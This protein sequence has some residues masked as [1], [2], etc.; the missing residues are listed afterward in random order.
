MYE[1]IAKMFRT[2]HALMMKN[3]PIT[4]FLWQCDL[5]EIKGLD[6]GKS[7]RN[8]E[9]ARIFIES[10]A[11]TEFGKVT[12]HIGNAK[13]VCVIGDGS[14][15]SSVKEQE[16]WFI[17]TCIDGNITVHFIGVHAT[18]KADARHI[19]QGLQH[20]LQN[21]LNIQWDTICKIIVALACDGA[22]VMTGCK[23][24][25]GAL[26]RETQP[27]LVTIHCMAH[28]LEL[29]LK[30]VMKKVPL[31]QKIVSILLKGLYLFY[32][33]SSLNNAML[34]RCY[35]ALKQKGDRLLIPTRSDGTRWIGHQLMAVT[36]VITSYKFITAH[37]GQV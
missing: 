5:D 13:F 23:A 19:V 28:R 31:Y 34:H 6:I 2:C 4:D 22:S 37:M 27:E 20:L 7:Y 30:D 17:R 21:N 36:T 29:S 35:D 1:K 15:D 25:V 12:S 8:K 24:G 32:H 18:E 14:T 16:M 10:I 11:V 3:R 26:L 9:A 33:K